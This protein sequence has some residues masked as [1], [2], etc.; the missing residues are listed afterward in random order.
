MNVL[1]TYPVPELVG[2]QLVMATVELQ[3]AGIVAIEVT[4]SSDGL[5]WLVGIGG[6]LVYRV[7]VAAVAPHTVRGD[8]QLEAL[9]VLAPAL[10][11]RVDAR[12]RQERQG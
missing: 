12:A 1:V 6:V 8:W 9:R 4:A 10:A 2:R 5:L 11:Q 7:T 3:R